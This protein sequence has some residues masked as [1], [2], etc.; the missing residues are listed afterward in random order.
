MTAH[1]L[2]AGFMLAAMFVLFLVIAGS[3]NTIVNLL[4]KL[5][6]LLIKEEEFHKE[7]L[8]IRKAMEQKASNE[9]RM[10]REREEAGGQS[11]PPS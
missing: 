2:I 8:L 4:R 9:E 7:A 10:Q 11:E 3:M 1:Y 6:Y 5:E